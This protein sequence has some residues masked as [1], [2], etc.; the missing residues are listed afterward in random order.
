MNKITQ[1]IMGRI[2]MPLKLNGLK[3]DILSQIMK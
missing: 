1:L 3:L 2:M